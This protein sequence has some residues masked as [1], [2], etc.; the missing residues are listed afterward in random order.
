LDQRLQDMLSF[1]RSMRTAERLRGSPVLQEAIS[2]RTPLFEELKSAIR[3]KRHVVITGSAGGGK[4]HLL[5]EVRHELSDEVRFCHVGSGEQPAKGEW[6]VRWHEDGTKL[7]KQERDGLLRDLDGGSLVIAIN[8]GPLRA[9][10]E[11]TEDE[12]AAVLFD[13]ARRFLRLGQLGAPLEDEDGR[14]LSAEHIRAEEHPIVIDVAGFD[15]VSNDQVM[16]ELLGNACVSDLVNERYPDSMRSREWALLHDSAVVSRVRRIISLASLDGEPVLWRDLWN[17]VGDM[18]IP[19]ED[20]PWYER[21]LFGES[22]ISRRIRRFLSL[23][24]MVLPHIDTALWQGEEGLSRL[25]A[26]LRPELP[27]WPAEVETRSRDPRA[28]DRQFRVA[29]LRYLLTSIEEHPAFTFAVGVTP[30]LSTQ[31]P[32]AVQRLVAR[33]NRFRLYSAAHEDLNTDLALNLLLQTEFSMREKASTTQVHLGQTRYSELTITQSRAV[34]GRPGRAE[35]PGSRYY[36]KGPR[37]DRGEAP[38]LR[39]TGDLWQRLERQR[40]LV[41]SDRECRE[42]DLDLDRFFYELVRP[43]QDLSIVHTS[44]ENMVAQ[45]VIVRVSEAGIQRVVT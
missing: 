33:I 26:A 39:L 36:L 8:E 38:S 1:L 13:H 4:T 34:V 31:G 11:E 7:T 6:F 20:Q 16:I 30:W 22:E 17:L 28:R 9:M 41:R 12:S 2:C 10:A 15:P 18:A 27:P 5:D 42:L 24:G 45:R 21:L 14:E 29:Q 37:L 32:A 40:A 35:V 43:G 19:E 25:Q 3:E 23:S 44:I